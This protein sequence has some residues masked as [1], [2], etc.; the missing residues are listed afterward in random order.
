MH[1]E[2]NQFERNNVWNLVDSPKD[3][4]IIETKWM[5]R[6]KLDEMGMTLE[7]RLDW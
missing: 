7:T 6:N 2:L 5:I 1:E 4:P 3:Y